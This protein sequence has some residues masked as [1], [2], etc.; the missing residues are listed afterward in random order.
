MAWYRFADPI[1]QTSFL[2]FGC[3]IGFVAEHCKNTVPRIDITDVRLR[4]GKIA[5]FTAIDIPQAMLD[6]FGNI[7]EPG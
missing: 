3:Q 7:L 5:F 2:E 1:K 4:S 6:H